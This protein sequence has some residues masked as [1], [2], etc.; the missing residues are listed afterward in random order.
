MFIYPGCFDITEPSS[1]KTSVLKGIVKTSE[2]YLNTHQVLKTKL[3]V[4]NIDSN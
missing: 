3:R 2:L 1:G 4:L